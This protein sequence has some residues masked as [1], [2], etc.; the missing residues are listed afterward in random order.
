MGYIAHDAIIAVAFPAFGGE[1]PAV[2]AF[3]E[4]LPEEWRP[5]VIGPIATIVNMDSV[6]AFLPDG[7]EEGWGTSNDGDQYR[8]E[9][10]ALFR[11]G[12]GFHAEMIAARFGGDYGNECGATVSEVSL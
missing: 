1:L 10:R 5:L 2:E 8:E 12:T 6:Y 11:D 4:S 7:S 9:F 3:R